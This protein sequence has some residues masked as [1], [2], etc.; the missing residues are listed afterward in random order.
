MKRNLFSNPLVHTSKCRLHVGDNLT[1]CMNNPCYTC[2]AHA[3]PVSSSSETLTRLPNTPNPFKNPPFSSQKQSEDRHMFHLWSS[4]QFQA[5]ACIERQ[6][7]WIEREGNAIRQLLDT[8]QNDA[9][10]T[11]PSAPRAGKQSSICLC[12]IHLVP[13][14][15]YS[16]WWSE[17]RCTCQRYLRGEGQ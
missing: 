7:Q 10:W 12:C 5:V 3:I 2:S 9:G 17:C 4:T 6:R 11:L 1:I 15:M 14:S 8:L 13:S 16:Y